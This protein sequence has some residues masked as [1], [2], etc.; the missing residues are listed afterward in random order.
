MDRNDLKVRAEGDRTIVITRSFD[1]P[2]AL[3]FGA[4]TKPEL[5]KRWLLGPDGWTFAS[6][7][8]DLRVGGRYRYVWVNADGSRLTLGG[9]FREIAAPSRLVA[10]EVF[11]GEPQFGEGLSVLELNETGGRTVVTQTV[12]YP[13]H[14][15]RDNML[16]SGMEAGMASSFT[17]LDDLLAS[18]AVAQGVG[19]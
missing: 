5:L 11:E 17:Q 3:V 9:E 8:V 13:S 1:A 19:P 12:T 15:A 18:E 2:R 14:D 16:A 6:C 4:W 7:E 10:T